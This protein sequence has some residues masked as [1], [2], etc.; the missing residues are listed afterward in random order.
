MIVRLA[1]SLLVASALLPAFAAAQGYPS[2]PV[3]IIV[4]AQ[5]GGGLDLTGRTVGAELGRALGQSFISESA[6]GGSSRRWRQR[7]ARRLLR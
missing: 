2:K 5:P 7:R 6:A 4:P 1:A 3:K